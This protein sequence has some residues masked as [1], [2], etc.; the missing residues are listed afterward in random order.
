MADQTPSDGPWSFGWPTGRQI[1]WLLMVFPKI[2]VVWTLFFN[3]IH[4]AFLGHSTE[5]L[6]DCPL[7]IRKG[8]LNH[9]GKY[10]LCLVSLEWRIHQHRKLFPINTGWNV[11]NFYIL[12]AT[13]TIFHQYCSGLMQV[14]HFKV[15]LGSFPVHVLCSRELGTILWEGWTVWRRVQ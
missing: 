9:G 4:P 7:L 1:L 3:H 14:L 6:H 2:L 8:L 15:Q 11:M 12:T 5:N 13:M 10:I